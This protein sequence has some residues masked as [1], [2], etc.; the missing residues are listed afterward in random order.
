MVDMTI[1]ELDWINWCKIWY[2]DL[3]A[4]VASRLAAWTHETWRAEYCDSGRYRLAGATSQ[5]CSASF[6][7]NNEL[8]HGHRMNATDT[9]VGGWDACLMRTFLNTRV[10]NALPLTWQS[11]L[12]TVKISASAGDKST[13]IITSEDKIYLAANREAWWMDYRTLCE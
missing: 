5:K 7:L 10:Y 4:D 3:G 11:M 8:H 9:N 12:K 6:I 13:E 1:M 2:Q